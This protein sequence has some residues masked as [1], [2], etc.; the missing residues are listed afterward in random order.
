MTQKQQKLKKIDLQ[1]KCQKYMKKKRNSRFCNMYKISKIK[2]II[3]LVTAEYDSSNQVIYFNKTYGLKK[4]L[5]NKNS[6][7]L[8]KQNRNPIGFLLSQTT[9]A[10]YFL[11]FF[12]PTLPCSVSQNSS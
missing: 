8:S 9:C 12:L 4:S 2:F 6:T 10:D 7:V 3:P 11:F 1:D 5:K